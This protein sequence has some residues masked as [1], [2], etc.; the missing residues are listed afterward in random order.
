[1]LLHLLKA[2]ELQ[3]YFKAQNLI[4]QM[5]EKELQ[6]KVHNKLNN[7]DT[8]IYKKKYLDS[9]KWLT[10]MME[11]TTNIKGWT[12][13]WGSQQCK[14]WE[15]Q[16]IQAPALPLQIVAWRKWQPDEATRQQW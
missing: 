12:N 4:L 7:M 9:D 10:Q 14:V 1:M 16:Y 15:S 5:K 11:A 2:W 6:D 3:S 8:S 13:T